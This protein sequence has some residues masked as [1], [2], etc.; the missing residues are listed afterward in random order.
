MR[1]NEVFGGGCNLAL[2]RRLQ[3]S[4]FGNPSYNLYF[5][6]QFD[7]PYFFFCLRVVKKGM[8]FIVSLF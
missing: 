7:P 3:P 2:G 1:L 6:H 8:V 5:L 4:S